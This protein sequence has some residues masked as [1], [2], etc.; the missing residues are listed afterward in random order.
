MGRLPIGEN[1]RVMWG[2]GWGDGRRGGRGIIRG[3]GEG[4]E[5]R[6]GD[7]RASG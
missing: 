7:G 4:D 3:R 1:R 2:F 6:G 5:R